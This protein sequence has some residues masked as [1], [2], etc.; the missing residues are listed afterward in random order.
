MAAAV[1]SLTSM[2]AMAAVQA[3]FVEFYVT[4]TGLHQSFFQV[5]PGQQ[6]Q[7]ASCDPDFGF[8]FVQCFTLRQESQTYHFAQNFYFDNGVA[9]YDYGNYRTI[10]E[11]SFTLTKLT[12]GY[13]LDNF[14]FGYDTIRSN[15]LYRLNGEFV[16]LSAPSQVVGV[17]EPAT[18]ALLFLGMG[19]I[20]WS[21]RRKPVV[22]IHLA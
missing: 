21:L 1:T 12:N 2:P 8:G 5:A 15:G 18:W 3:Q 13:R 10:G 6:P 17:P 20:G 7:G 19:A 16:S 11:T 4:A 22:R 14:S 9:S